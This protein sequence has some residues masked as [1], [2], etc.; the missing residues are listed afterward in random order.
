MVE[1][2]DYAVPVLGAY[3]VTFVVLI[4]LVYWSWRQSVQSVR[5]LEDAERGNGEP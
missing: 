3:A 2:G 4:V 5:D 1:L